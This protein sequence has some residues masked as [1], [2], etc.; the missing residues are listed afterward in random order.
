[1]TKTTTAVSLAVCAGLLGHRVAR[2]E[3]RTSGL[4][5]ARISPGQRLS[6]F[7]PA[8]D[9]PR[10]GGEHATEAVLSSRRDSNRGRCSGEGQA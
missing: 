9:I 1:M 2:D 10:R 7:A 6:P 8:A 4:G 3:T 5:R